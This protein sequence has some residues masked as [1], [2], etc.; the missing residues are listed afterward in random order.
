LASASAGAVCVDEAWLAAF[1][2]DR[3]SLGSVLGEW[4]RVLAP[5]GSLLLAFANGVFSRLPR[6]GGGRVPRLDRRLATAPGSPL[7]SGIRTWLRLLSRSGFVPRGLFA[8]LP[9]DNELRLVLPVGDRRAAAY[10]LRSLL[11]RNSVVVRTALGLGLL[12]ARLGL[13]E[14]VLPS[15]FALLD[16][17][18]EPS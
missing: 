1:D 15:Y 9:D 8:P 3:A 5:G 2:V 4:R 13:L 14:R 18:G 17:S 7:R 10:C 16:A 11:R 12:S 6:W